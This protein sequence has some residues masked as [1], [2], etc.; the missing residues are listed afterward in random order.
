MKIT[1]EGE[2]SY[3]HTLRDRQSKCFRLHGH[4]AKITVEIIGPV[5]PNG[6]VMDY[7]KIKKIVMEYDHVY[8]VPEERVRYMK[9]QGTVR[10]RISNADHN[11]QAMSIDFP[12]EYADPFPSSKNRRRVVKTITGDMDA[13]AENLSM[14]LARRIL[15]RCPSG[16]KSVKVTWRESSHTSATHIESRTTKG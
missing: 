11:G 13:T 10:V 3:A 7:N 14:V 16:V 4:N 15:A 5:Q 6:M 8:I 1:W 12:L 2:I 9:D